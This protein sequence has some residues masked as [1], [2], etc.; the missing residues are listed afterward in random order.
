MTDTEK[1][2]FFSRRTLLKGIGVGAAALTVGN[3]VSSTSTVSA[4]SNPT[5]ADEA[6]FYR[7]RMGSFDV[8]VIT[9][10]YLNLPTAV[11]GTNASEGAVSA[12]LADNYLP[13][14]LFVAPTHAMLVN[15]GDNLVL[16]DTGLGGVVLPGFETDSG[17]LVPTM[18]LLGIDPA[19][20]DTLIVTHAHPDHIG[21]ILD[22]NGAPQ[23]PNATYHISQAEWDFWLNAPT[24]ASDD[25]AN[26]F[27]TLAQNTLLPLEDRVQKFDGETVIVPGVSVVPAPGH[28]PGHCA[29]MIG[30]GDDRVL[31]IADT[32]LHYIIGLEEPAWHTGLEIDPIAAEQSRIALLSRASTEKIKVFGYHFP[33]PGIGYPVRDGDNDRWEFVITG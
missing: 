26:F 2:N 25:L 30:T 18:R 23:F 1:P 27:A 4:Q 8:T 10:G 13:T 28:T 3:L 11:L 31:N 24:D 7:F 19:D 22:A 5:R 17:K 14:D 9:D 16:I 29:V 20:V 6:A 33:F 15:T 21:G 12:L 32:T